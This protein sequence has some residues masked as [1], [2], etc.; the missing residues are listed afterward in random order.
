MADSPRSGLIKW[1][2]ESGICPYG[3]KIED[4]HRQRMKSDRPY[5]VNECR[6]HIME[7][8]DALIQ[9]RRREHSQ[10]NLGRPKKADLQMMK[11]VGDLPFAG[12]GV[13]LVQFVCGHVSRFPRTSLWVYN[14]R[15]YPMYCL[16]CNDERR[17]HQVSPATAVADD[18]T[19]DKGMVY[20]PL[21]ERPPMKIWKHVK[22]AGSARA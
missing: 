7:M 14:R 2:L 9:S 11:R 1:D 12:E 22:N 10:Q 6:I 5:P 3:H 4:C 16:T 17:V 18:G 21:E 19:P 8:R 20:H 15:S 13:A